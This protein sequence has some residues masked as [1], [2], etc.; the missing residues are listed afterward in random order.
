MESL[1]AFWADAGI[2]VCL[3]D[4]PVNRLAE[5]A[6]LARPSAAPVASLAPARGESPAQRRAS[7]DI[8]ALAQAKTLAAEAQSLEA[9][10]EALLSFEGCGLRRNLGHQPVLWRGALSSK[11]MIIAEAPLTEDETE[12][13]PG[14]EGQLLDRMLQAA[15]LKDRCILTHTVFWHP[16]GGR[17]PSLAEQKICQPFLERAIDLIQPQYL[18]L[19]GAAS[20]RAMLGREDGILAL[21]GQWF[22][23]TASDQGL[24]LPALVTMT[25]GFLLQQSAAKKKAWADLQSFNARALGV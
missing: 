20:A 2:D 24:T 15:G 16:P 3:E 1:L 25:P 23:W 13:R 14:P 10:A 6:H 9:L 7:N 4:E 21:R 5:V 18:L 17:A 12:A 22:D 11:I 19:L 8:A